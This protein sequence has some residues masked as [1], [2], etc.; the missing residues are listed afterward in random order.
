M[1]TRGWGAIVIATLGTLM[2]VAAVAC[3][4]G[5]QSLD[6]S[7]FDRS[8]SV[9]TDC[10]LV[11]IVRNCHSCC[12]SSLPVRNSAELRQ[13]LEELDEGCNEGTICPMDC[14]DKAV[15][16]NGMCTKSSAGSDG[17]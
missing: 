15:C 6:P 13:A 5:R 3:E 16:T 2:T 14:T 8:C 1:K 9:D 10:V 11:P 17:G 12:G 4:S 7:S